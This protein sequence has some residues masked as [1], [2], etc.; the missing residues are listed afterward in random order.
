MTLQR[1]DAARDDIG[2]LETPTVNTAQT[3]YS[4]DGPGSCA[5]WP[6]EPP[7]TL[8]ADP[9]GQEVLPGPAADSPVQG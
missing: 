6:V 8:S 4:I 1:P 9:L 5:R 3:P 7:E 2:N